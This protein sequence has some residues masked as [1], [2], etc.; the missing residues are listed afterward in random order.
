MN[1]LP[2]AI[3]FDL[4]DTLISFGRRRDHLHQA[5]EQFGLP[6]GTG[7]ALEARFKHFWDDPVRHREWRFKLGEARVHVMGLAFADLGLPA[8][9]A[10]P[11]AERFHAWREEQVAFFPQAVET[12]DQLKAQGVKL[13]LVTNGA[14]EPQRAKIERFELAHRFD[15][16][17]IE[18]EAGF[19]KPEERA[20]LHAMEALGVGPD[21]TWMVGDNLEWEVAAPQRLGIYGIWHDHLGDGLPPDSRVRP[22]RVIRAIPELLT[23]PD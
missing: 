10:R 20:Y 12:V 23:P 21:E 7:D 8:D 22:D 13:A 19:G 1:H 17:Q 5:A 14:A 6:A 16:L 11:V 18:G 15:H 4:D 2:R 9:L 3:L